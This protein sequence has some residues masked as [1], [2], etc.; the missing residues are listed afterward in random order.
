[1]HAEQQRYW[2]ALLNLQ[3]SWA[4]DE[5]ALAFVP[6]RSRDFTNPPDWPQKKALVYLLNALELVRVSHRRLE[7]GEPLDYEALNTVLEGLHLRLHPGPT[8]R[9]AARRRRPDRST[10]AGSRR[11]R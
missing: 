9:S 3:R 1:M 4:T 6:P 2:I 7:A 5:A 11:C 10:A 8:S